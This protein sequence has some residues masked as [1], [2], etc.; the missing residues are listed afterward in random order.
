MILLYIL[1]ISTASA[2]SNPKYGKVTFINGSKQ[3]VQVHLRPSLTWAHFESRTNK[4]FGTNP[5]RPMGFNRV[6]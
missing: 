5:H 6:P 3:M 2:A 4:T 1:V